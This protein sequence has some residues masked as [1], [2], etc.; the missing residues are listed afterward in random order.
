MNKDILK[1]IQHLSIKDKKSLSQKALK[2][3]E[4]C[5]EL[6]KVVLPYEG[7]YAT[8][9]RFIDKEAILEEVADVFLTAI[10]IAYSNGHSDEEIEEMIEKKTILWQELQAKEDKVEYPIPYEIHVTISKPES[11]EKF[12]N[13]CE[14]I[15]VKPIFLDLGANEIQDVMTSSNH[16]GDNTSAYNE[17]K[18]INHALS[19][20]SGFKVIREKIETIPWHPAAPS[21]SDI[22]PNM[23]INCYFESHISVVCHEDGKGEKTKGLLEGAVKMCNAHLSKNF[24][25]KIGDGKFINMVTLRDYKCTY[26]EFKEKL[27]QLKKQLD[28]FGFEFEKEV[29]EFSIYD[30]KV[31][32]DYNW[33][34]K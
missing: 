10:S 30:T 11:I 13:A 2:L 12:K 14:E 3:S 32:H 24:F 25:K 8:N 26:E 21:K 16:F 1:F 28:Y 17:M 22:N 34:N 7:A 19:M 33:L 29:V 9:H 27:E 18:R 23:P 20:G 31:S 6:A 5:G 4:E 15:G